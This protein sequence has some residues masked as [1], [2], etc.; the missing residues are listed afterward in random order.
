[1][2]WIIEGIYSF[3]FSL[4]G[5]EISSDNLGKTVI[6]LLNPNI[7]MNAQKFTLYKYVEDINLSMVA[8]GTSLLTLFFMIQ[9]VKLLT[10]DGVER[11][12]WQKIVLRVALF[13]LLAAFVKGSLS[14]FKEISNMIYNGIY[15]PVEDKIGFKVDEVPFNLTEEIMAIINSQD[16]FLKEVLYTGVFIILAIPY[17]ASII[18]ILSQV[19]LRAVKLLLYMMFSPIPIALAAEGDTYR[20]KAISFFM[21]F[22]GVCFEAVIIYIGTFIYMTGMKSAVSVDGTF[23]IIIAI[24]FNNGLFAALISLSSQLSDRFFG[25]G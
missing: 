13:F 3:A 7:I 23:G 24:L 12:S 19:F 9:L 22:A 8:I 1:M 14:F 21:Q 17:M 6:N 10:Q 20:G 16:N 4:F 18:M 15:L 25:R 11:A 5:I 2:E